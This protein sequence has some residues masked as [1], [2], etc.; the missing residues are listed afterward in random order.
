MRFLHWAT[1]LKSP[2]PISVTSAA[3]SPS[4]SSTVAIFGCVQRRRATQPNAVRSFNAWAAVLRRRCGRTRSAR[5]AA[6]REAAVWH[7]G[8]SV[9]SRI[10]CR[11]CALSFCPRLRREAAFVA[12]A[13]LRSKARKR[14]SSSVMNAVRS[15]GCARAWSHRDLGR[16][17]PAALPAT[18]ATTRP[19][20]AAVTL[21]G[22]H[23][24]TQCGC[25][26]RLSKETNT[27][28]CRRNDRAPSATRTRPT[29]R[30]AQAR[31]PSHHR[32]RLTGCHTS[33]DLVHVPELGSGKGPPS[34]RHHLQGGE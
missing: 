34:S 5:I 13:T 12:A 7:P 31:L 29:P 3:P 6:K 25:G 18:L 19:W 28:P 27:K 33:Q 16:P 9:T 24:Q 1:L 20:S 15:R 23:A 32:R 10:F 4:A 26:R 2:P 11:F 30:S 22:A 21:G 8:N 14:A 17:C